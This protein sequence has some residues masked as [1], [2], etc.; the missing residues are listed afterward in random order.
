MKGSWH[1]IIVFTLLLPVACRSSAEKLEQS[2]EALEIYPDYTSIT[3]PPNI[4]PMN[5]QIMNQ[6][7]DFAVKISNSHG[8]HI[9]IRSSSG[10]I[11][12]PMKAWKKTLERD[13]GGKLTIAV[14]RKT[15]GGK[16][17][18]LALI[19]NEISAE[20][21]DPYIAFRKIPPANIIW[22]S[23]G[24]Y[25]RSLESFKE[26]PIMVNSLTDD[27]C[28]NCHSFNA[29]DPEQIMFHMRGPYGGTL[30]KSKNG[31]QFVNT[32]SDHT[33]SNAAYPSWHPDGDLIA[34]SVNKINQGFHASIGKD[35]Q[36]IDKYSDIVL[37]D[38]KN[39]SITRP[40]ELASEKLENLPAWSVDGRRLY[41]LCAD[42]YNDTLPYDGILYNLMCIDFNKE[43]RKFGNRDTLISSKDFGLSI[44]HPRESPTGG[45]ISFVGLDYGYFSIFNNEADVYLLDTE[46]GE[47]KSP[48]INSAF[49]ESYPSWSGNGSWLMFVSK[50][51]DGVLSQVWFSHIDHEGIAGKPFVLPQKNP[52]FY[53]NYMYNY[54]RPEFIS[55]KVG[56]NPRKVF[57]IANKGAEASTFNGAESV[58]LSTG[59][60]LPASKKD[61]QF[62]RHD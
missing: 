23:M 20:D 48:G 55:G 42:Y 53:K 56:L 51:D 54:N 50:R 39:N 16:W 61:D 60:T 22:K 17:E 4:A 35:L 11:M 2:G 30:V 38:I 5:F 31:T 21:I 19:C 33:R 18:N 41:Y 32:K 37:Y 8:K 27:N 43:T 13:R 47:I 25:Q 34:F 57:S 49:T 7:E 40:A 15:E 6:G 26:I 44:T 14:S 9:R 46:T 59:A 1:L 29:G 52:E 58:S 3:I 24:L 36:V 10:S 28:M 12:I 45:L 62:Y